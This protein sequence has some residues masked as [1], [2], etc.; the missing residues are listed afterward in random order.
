MVAVI[1]LCRTCGFD[2]PVDAHGCPSCTGPRP[3]PPSRAAL[4]V[5]GFE[6]PTRS[7]HTLPHTRAARPP[8][9]PIGRAE[10]A[11]FVFSC[12]SALAVLTFALA[13]LSWLSEQPRFVLQ[14]PEGTVALLDDV[15][16][17]SATASVVALALGLAALAVWCVR[18]TLRRLRRLA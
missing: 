7:V 6:L 15:T 10:V 1:E 17:A 18:G 2:L 3:R 5:A 8:A 9:R 12:S 13:G 11:R 16:T 4:Q 14:V